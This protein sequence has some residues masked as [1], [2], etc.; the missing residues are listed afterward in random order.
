[1]QSAQCASSLMAMKTAW[2]QLRA[3]EHKCAAVSGSEFSSRFFRPGFY[4]H[5]QSYRQTGEVPLEAAF[6]RFT[7][8]DGA[9]A[10]ILETRPNQR[11]LSLKKP[12]S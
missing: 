7:L 6:L 9:G 5:T 10:A 3:D 4:E 11:Q 1:M 2:L 8:S 12:A